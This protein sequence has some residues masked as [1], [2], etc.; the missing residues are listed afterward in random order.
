MV[1]DRAGKVLFSTCED[2][3]IR[4]WDVKKGT[5]LW[6]AEAVA[7]SVSNLDAGE[8]SLAYTAGFPGL[9][10]LETKA[11]KSLGNMGFPAPTAAT[12]IACDPD[13][14]WAWLGF[15]DGTVVRLDPKNVNTW[16]KR[17][18][19]NGG[20]ICFAQ[21][22][23]AKLMAIGGRDGTIR[24]LNPTSA[25][26]D[27]KKLFEGHVKPVSALRFDGKGS[28]LASGDEAGSVRVWSVASGKCTAEW[29]AHEGAVRW[30]ALHPKNPW[31]AT[32]G[33]DGAIEL[34]KLDGGSRIMTIRAAGADPVVGLGFLDKGAALASAGGGN[35]LEI[36]DLSSL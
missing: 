32:G 9:E 35:E 22:D 14:R 25:S 28:S 20:V 6:K 27:E 24:F 30:I 31:I 33:A 8:E 34:W 11:G 26:K 23:K 10:I 15:E 16:N 1:V 3:E 21:D 13:G 18:M 7:P 29:K 36:W 19:E 17:S 4:A 2:R 5:L 12:C